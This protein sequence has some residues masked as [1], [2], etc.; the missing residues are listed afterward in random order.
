MPI[1]I[2]SSS[3]PRV[4][5]KVARRDSRGHQALPLPGEESLTRSPM[6]RQ[7]LRQLGVEAE[8]LL[9]TDSAMMLDQSQHTFNVFHVAEASGSP[10]IPAQGEFVIPHAIRSVIG[11]GGLLLPGELFATILFTRAP[12]SRQAAELFTTLA[13]N[14]KVALLPFAGDR[15]FS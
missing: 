2:D 3:A 11:F 13:L 5:C 7:L 6:I 14:V 12:V 9:S 1:R 8:T 4:I 10:Y 15:I